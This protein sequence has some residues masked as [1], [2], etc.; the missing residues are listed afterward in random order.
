MDEELQTGE[1]VDVGAERPQGS[2]HH[3]LEEEGLGVGLSLT[4][5]DDVREQHEV[6][7]A[8]L[9]CDLGSVDQADHAFAPDDALTQMTRLVFQIAM[10]VSQT[11][12][13]VGPDGNSL[14]VSHST[15]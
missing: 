9:H 4:G 8:G 5:L 3:R 13:F 7:A 10:W 6:L 14:G 11:T 15:I 2:H 1:D 12:L